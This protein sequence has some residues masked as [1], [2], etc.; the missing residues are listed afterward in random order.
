MIRFSDKFLYQAPLLFPV[1]I[2]GIYVLVHPDTQE[3][4]YVGKSNY[5]PRRLND[6][7]ND[8]RRCYKRGRKVS[9]N[10]F[11]YSLMD[12]IADLINLEKFPVMYVIEQVKA[13]QSELRELYWINHY[14]KMGARSLND[15]RDL[16]P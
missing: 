3:V 12:W 9:S 8:M 13:E 5:P 15:S 1:G 11:G 14:H 10:E 16:T 6:H 2:E 7:I 4:R